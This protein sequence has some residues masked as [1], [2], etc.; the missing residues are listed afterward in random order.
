[1]RTG[2]T[3]Q[4]KTM[5]IWLD[6]KGSFIHIYTNNTELKNRRTRYSQQHQAYCKLTDNDLE[7]GCKEFEIEKGRFCIQLTAHTARNADGRQTK[8]PSKTVSTA[9]CNNAVLVVK[10][11]V[12]HI[13]Q[14]H[15]KTTKYQIENVC[16]KVTLWLKICK[17]LRDSIAL[18]LHFYGKLAIM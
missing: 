12:L 5:D 13:S 7:I 8:T 16:K 18:L 14:L 15:S 4:E 11:S 17:L 3:K 2:L 9:R 10:I 1:M 6:E